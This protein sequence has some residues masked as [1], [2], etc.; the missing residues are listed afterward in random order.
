VTVPPR[1]H[2]PRERELVAVIS[3]LA[4]GAPDSSV[5]GPAPARSGGAWEVRQFSAR[6]TKH[7]YFAPRGFLHLQLWHPTAAISIL[8]PSR[9][10]GG[11]Y[12]V[13]DGDRV[14][15]PAWTDVVSYLP[16][17]APPGRARLAALER[18][19]VTAHETPTVALL[20]TWWSVKRAQRPAGAPA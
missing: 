19:F 16:D 20:R 8:T 2:D 6:D 5:A 1:P 17:L 18:W 11:N 7:D 15:L 3:D 12:E 4:F 13:H 10:T 9:L 14:V